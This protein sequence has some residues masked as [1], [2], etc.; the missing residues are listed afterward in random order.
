MVTALMR[1]A[2]RR[3]E[4]KRPSA[5]KKKNTP[6]PIHTH[7]FLMDCC[8]QQGKQPLNEFCVS[9]FVRWFRHMCLE[10]ENWTEH[11]GRP[12][13]VSVSLEHSHVQSYKDYQTKPSRDG[14][15]RGW[16]EPG[17]AWLNAAVADRNYGAAIWHCCSR[18]NKSA[19]PNEAQV[20]GADCRHEAGIQRTPCDSLHSK[21]A[22][23]WRS[24][25]A[26]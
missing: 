20:A 5:K 8:N 13:S 6:F 22:T 16:L 10:R 23:I 26:T 2:T 25:V 21:T 19:V 3:L 18:H 11:G 14:Y 7:C 1:E 17:S 4:G 24:N 12:S 9:C 15:G